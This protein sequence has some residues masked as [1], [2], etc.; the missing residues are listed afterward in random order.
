MQG[1][2][3][4]KRLV[5]APKVKKTSFSEEELGKIIQA[6][7]KFPAQDLPHTEFKWAA[8]ALA[9]SGA[10]CMEIVQLRHQD[11]RRVDG[12][13]VFD[14]KTVEEGHRVKNDPSARFAP[15]HSQLVQLGFLDWLAQR[16]Q[17]QG[18][19]SRVFPLIHP[20]GS[21]LVS[22]WFMR[23]L[24]ALQ[25]KRPEVS[26]HSLRHTVTVKLAQARTYPPLQNRL[27][28]HAIGK[29]VEDRV[30]L[31]W[32]TFTVKELSEALERMNFPT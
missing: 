14:I 2:S 28:G 13:W 3:L 15:V 17:P 23:L 6:L 30:Y 19:G 10:R 26:L 21:P 29:S 20:K 25:M 1:L 16:P 8:L 18:S 7:L 31:A 27:L 11:V 24:R 4:P 12:V 5:S 9:F 22:M 32:L